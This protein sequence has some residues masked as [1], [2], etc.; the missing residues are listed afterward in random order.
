[1]VEVAEVVAQ[2][3]LPAA[4]QGE[5]RLELA[6]DGQDRPR[7]V[8]RASGSA[9]GRSRASG[10]PAVRRPST[11]RV[12]ESSQRTWIGRSWVRNR[13]AMPASRLE[14]VVVLVGDRLVGAVAAG[15]HQRDARRPSRSRRW[16]SGV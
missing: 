15:H 12:T 1:M 11:T 14:R 8:E 13:S 7:A 6:A 2:E 4:A 3:R 16:C 10:G 5:R 9:A